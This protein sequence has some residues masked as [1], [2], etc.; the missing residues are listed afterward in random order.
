MILD[1]CI[2]AW[3]TGQLTISGCETE[4]PLALCSP[5]V[6]EGGKCNADVMVGAVVVLGRFSEEPDAAE[7]LLPVALTWPGEDVELPAFLLKKSMMLGESPLSSHDL[8]LEGTAEPVVA[9]GAP[10]LPKYLAGLGLVGLGF[11]TVGTPDGYFERVDGGLTED[12]L[13]VIEEPVE[14]C[15][16][17]LCNKLLPG[18]EGVFPS[19]PVK[20]LE[21]VELLSVMLKL[22][23]SCFTDL[24]LAFRICA[25]PV[26]RSTA[27]SPPL[28]P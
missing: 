9:P 10:W 7:A 14:F 13:G 16:V 4:E 23:K 3:H 18:D 8:F 22:S 17:P 11:D 24:C 15:I 28:P 26:R 6:E 21:S 2:C 5:G 12:C 1:S 19:L 27:A 25:S 20:G